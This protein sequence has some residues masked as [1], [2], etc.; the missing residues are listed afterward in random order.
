MRKFQLFFILLLSAVLFSSSCKDDE[1]SIPNITSFSFIGVPQAFTIDQTA[2]TI[3]ND[4]A[5][6]AGE[7]VT[8]L[9]AEFSFPGNA[10]VYVDGKE[11]TGGLSAN[12]FSSPVVYTVTSDNGSKEY[13]V[14]VNV[15]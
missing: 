7:S 5:L 13:T 14:T 6:P 4:E 8:A 11:Q 10:I 1:G 12:D 3:S 2:C 15:E 9:I